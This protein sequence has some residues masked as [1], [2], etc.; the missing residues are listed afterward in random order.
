[1]TLDD[2]HKAVGVLENI[3]DTFDGLTRSQLTNLQRGL[4]V[5]DLRVNMLCDRALNSLWVI[6][7]KVLEKAETLLQ[8]L[9][10]EMNANE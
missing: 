10:K 2:Y 8:T 7:Q 9:K 6:R 3:T 1:M 4:E 5:R